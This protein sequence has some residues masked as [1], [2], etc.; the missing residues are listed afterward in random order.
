MDKS[1]THTKFRL[2]KNPKRLGFIFKPYLN[3]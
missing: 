2:S 1:C 3:F